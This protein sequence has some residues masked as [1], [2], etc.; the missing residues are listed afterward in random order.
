[1]NPNTNRRRFFIHMGQMLGLALIAPGLFT[2][3]VLAEERRRSRNEGGPSSAGSA[4]GKPVP[5][6][7]QPGVGA[8]TAVNY[9]HKH[10][11][12]KDQGLKIDRGGVPFEKQFCN[13]CTFYTKDSTKGGEEVGKCQ[14]FP[15]QLVKGTAWC[16]T[17]T[18]KA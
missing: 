18:K 17:W 9:V 13:N 6:M 3:R 12:I 5:V 4:A 10:S 1:M 7:V 8:A 14:I 15:N 2:S 16:S 11:D